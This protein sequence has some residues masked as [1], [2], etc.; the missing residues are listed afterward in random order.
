MQKGETLFSSP[1]FVPMPLLSK[2]R[3]RR[4]SEMDA[5]TATAIDAGK[6]TP[7]MAAEALA[8]V[9]GLQEAL[10]R[11]YS[12]GLNSYSP[13]KARA[14]NKIHHALAEHGIQAEE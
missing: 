12:F 5:R 6:G 14:W 2:S 8:S 4:W 7:S 1:S 3:Y 10:E 13:G 11:I 9:R